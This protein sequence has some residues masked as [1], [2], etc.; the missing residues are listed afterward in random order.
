MLSSQ[1]NF[2]SSLHPSINSLHTGEEVVVLMVLNVLKVQRSAHAN[3]PFQPIR[4][5][6]VQELDYPASVSSGVRINSTRCTKNK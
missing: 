4:V 5:S 1:I 3:L 2:S 6:W